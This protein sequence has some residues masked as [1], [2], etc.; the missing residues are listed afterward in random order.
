MLER[1]H[2]RARLIA[3]LREG[4]V[5]PDDWAQ[6]SASRESLRVRIRILRDLG[7]GIETVRTGKGRHSRKGYYRLIY[8]PKDFEGDMAHS[9][10]KCAI[11]SP[12]R[13]V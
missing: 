8:E 13:G 10:S 2:S 5:D 3:A 4:P 7:Y 11:P 9:Q 6:H 12:A 1:F